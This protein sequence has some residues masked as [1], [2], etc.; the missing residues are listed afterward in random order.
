[1][2]PKPSKVIS[3]RKVLLLNP[4][5]K[6]VKVDVPH[7]GLAMLSSMLKQHGHEVLVI[8]YQ[9]SQDAPSIK[10]IMSKFMP[11]VVGIS[12]TTAA[13]VEAD[14]LI[15]DIRQYNQHVPIMIGGPHATL[16]TDEFR[17][18]SRT[19]YVFKG[20]AE[21]SIIK[22]VESAKRESA[23]QVI[24]SPLPNPDELPYPDFTSFYNMNTFDN[25]PLITSRGCPYN[26]SFCVVHL[27]SSKKWRQRNPKNCINEL[28]HAK[29]CLPNL[30]MVTIED[31]N[32]ALSLDRFKELLRLF[33]N[34]N[35]GWRLDIANMRADCVDE[36]LIDLLKKANC[37][38]IGLGIEHGDPAVFEQIG[39]GESLEDIRRAVKTMKKHGLEVYGCF[40]IGLPNDSFLKTYSSISLAK[41]LELDYVYWNMIVPYKG[42][43]V[44]RWFEQFGRLFNEVGHSSYTGTNTCEEPVC[45]SP[46]FTV[47]ERRKA[48]LIALLETNNALPFSLHDI[49][50]L[51]HVHESRLIPFVIK[52]NCKAKFLKWF[53]QRLS[54]SISLFMKRYVFRVFR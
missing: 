31:D 2:K 8:D 51:I 53:L 9:I 5:K 6:G 22:I 30:K 10:R 47:E 27:I 26:C 40:I 46:D 16:Y 42:S 50:Q 43:R 23:P 52:Y 14:K 19:D 39:K 36:E 38:T 45:D 20:E 44:R 34:E 33:I 17:E 29:K 49:V 48:Y 54:A 4:K 15:D 3:R 12:I 1:M 37:H 32:A 18:D 41:E 21:L 24:I 13:A 35:F 11:D 25:Y 28:K 7:V